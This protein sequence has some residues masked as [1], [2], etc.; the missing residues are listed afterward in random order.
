MDA[1]QADTQDVVVEEKREKD[2]NDDV[3]R[4]EQQQ[5]QNSIDNELNNDDGGGA[6]GVIA[7]VLVVLFLIGAGILGFLFYKKK[8]KDTHATTED[9]DPEEV[10]VQMTTMESPMQ[11]KKAEEDDGSTPMQRKGAEEDDD[12][13]T[14]MDSD[15]PQLHDLLKELRLRDW[16]N[17][18]VLHGIHNTDHLLRVAKTE[19]FQSI[20]LRTL[21]IRRL[22]DKIKELKHETNDLENTPAVTEEEKTVNDAPQRKQWKRRFSVATSLEYYENTNTGRVQV[23][24][25]AA[26]GG[27]DEVPED[28]DDSFIDTTGAKKN[29]NKLKSSI[30]GANAFKKGNKGNIRRLSKVMK[31]RRASEIQMNLKKE[32]MAEVAVPQTAQTEAMSYVMVQATTVL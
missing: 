1:V 13:S 20:G 7:A 24:A 21:Q 8:Q 14:P 26:F 17:K 27:V 2:V 25:P 15:M 4:S 5:E 18:F 10:T 29:W 30:K 11:R 22:E 6:G 31:G 3:T 32:T 16:I 12:G 23:T 9:S 28:E 19:D